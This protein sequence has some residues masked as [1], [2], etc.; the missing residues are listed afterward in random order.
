M[1]EANWTL[2]DLGLDTSSVRRGVTSGIARPNGGGNFCFGFNSVVTTPGVVGYFTNQANFAPIVAPKGGS[3]RG[4]IQRG[5][6]GGP[7][8][9]APMLYICLQ[10]HT[11][12]D[13]A[14]ILGL[15][16]EDPHRIVLRKGPLIEGVPAGAPDPDGTYHIIR[17]STATVVAGAWKHLRLDVIANPSGDV[18][19]KVFESDL[20]LHAVTA[21]DWQT[22]SGMDDF[23]DDSLG[24]ATGSLPLDT[25][26]AGFAFHTKNVSRRGYFDH[27]E[28]QRQLTP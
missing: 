24:V 21:P 9:F 1:G 22:I 19:L 7:L 8:D 11:I 27:L 2:L 15:S 6:S 18:I 12:N 16:D 23:V 26:Y 14:Y 17:R 3:V 20:A 5:P 13:I 10:D 28:V 4:A 25:G